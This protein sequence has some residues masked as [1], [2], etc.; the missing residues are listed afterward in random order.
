M[1]FVSQGYAQLVELFRSMSAG[2][3]LAT[4]LLLV[5]VV[6]SLA[7]LFQFQASGGDEY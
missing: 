1:D 5:I 7:Y 2:T 3:R 6:V 4:A